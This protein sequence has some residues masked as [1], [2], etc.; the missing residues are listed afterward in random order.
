VV[1]QGPG[2]Q[3][4][5]TAG[6]LEASVAQ[7]PAEAPMR[8]HSSDAAITVLGTRFRFAAHSGSSELHVHSGRVAVRAAGDHPEEWEVAAGQR[9]VL[10]RLQPPRRW[11]VVAGPTVFSHD[12]R[13]DLPAGWR[14]GDW[15]PGADGSLANGYVTGDTHADA[16]PGGDH[17]F[18]RSNGTYP[19]GLGAYRP[20]DLVDIRV[21]MSS[22]DHAMLVLRMRNPGADATSNLVYRLQNDGAHAD[23]AGWQDLSIPLSSF[24]ATEAI[25]LQP[26]ARYM[27]WYLHQ[28]AEQDVA[29]QAIRVTRGRRVPVDGG[30]P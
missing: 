24:V 30:V 8:I 28:P 13:G 20:G 16:L 10:S 2:K 14:A 3:L 4:Q 29:V 18:I 12:F 5:L 7:Q 19:D 27:Q 11:Q 26:G 6:S 25:Q 1:L 21:R 17:A 15:R 22:A 23:A 9:V